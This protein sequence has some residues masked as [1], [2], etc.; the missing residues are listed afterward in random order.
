M[1]RQGFLVTMAVAG[2]LVLPATALAQTGAI[3]GE[4]TDETGGVLRGD[5]HRDQSGRN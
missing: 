3:S 5:G 4:V 1:R 2:A